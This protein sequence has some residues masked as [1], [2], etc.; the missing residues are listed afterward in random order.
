M[1]RGCAG[2]A[3][4]VARTKGDGAES[5][6]VYRGERRTYLKT[7]QGGGCFGSSEGIKLKVKM[8]KIRPGIWQKI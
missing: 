7:E 6:L 3:C 5:A 2:R 4:A 1:Q 8:I